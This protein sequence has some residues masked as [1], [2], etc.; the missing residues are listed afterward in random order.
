MSAK[1]RLFGEKTKPEKCI[2][3]NILPPVFTNFNFQME[4]NTFNQIYPQ[5]TRN[6]SIFMEHTTFYKEDLLILSTL[7]RLLCWFNRKCI[8]FF[9]F[10]F[11]KFVYF[12]WRLITLQY[13]GG[14]CYTLT[15]VSHGCTLSPPHPES[16]S[17]LLSIPSRWIVPVHLLWVPCFMHQTWTGDPFHIW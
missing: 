3:E 13:C 1:N 17:H 15:W 7:P 11:L 6:L 12:N 14:F 5:L 16:P 2:C 9:F 4:Y 8:L 10:N